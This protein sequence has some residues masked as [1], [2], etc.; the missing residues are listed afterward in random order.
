M[1]DDNQMYLARVY[2]NYE[3]IAKTNIRKITLGAILQCLIEEMDREDERMWTKMTLIDI[4]SRTL[5]LIW[6]RDKD[7]RPQHP[8][9][10]GMKHI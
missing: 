10:P 3:K 9:L 5:I 8:V 2:R 7:G 4:K 1:D 6:H